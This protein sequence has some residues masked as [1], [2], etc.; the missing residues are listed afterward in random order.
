MGDTKQLLA[1]KGKTFVESCVDALLDS[2]VAEVVVVTGHRHAEVEAAVSDRP[3]TFAF[4]E[5]YRAGMASSIKRGVQAVSTGSSGCL[6]A[7]C[8][9]PQISTRVVDMLIDAFEATNPLFVVPAFEGTRGH[10]LLVNLSLKGEIM[11]LDAERGLRQVVLDHAEDI[12]MIE[13]GEPGVLVDFDLPE[14][15]ERLKVNGE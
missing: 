15:Y 2:S 4:N 11:N 9:Q 13:T 1:F 14:E 3:V 6:I 12:V 8:D 10:P 7:L 5:G